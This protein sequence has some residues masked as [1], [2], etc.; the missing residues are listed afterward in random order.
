MK[1]FFLASFIY[2]FLPII[3]L[4][5]NYKI[6]EDLMTDEKEI[7]F[8]ILSEN[9]I[10]NSIGVQ[11]KAILSF[12]C[13]KEPQVIFATRTYNADN[14]ELEIR[15]NK[16]FVYSY[17]WDPASKSIAY[18]HRDPKRF[19]ERTEESDLVTIAWIPYKRR[20]IAAR[21]DLNSQSWK[22]NIQRAKDDGCSLY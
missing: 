16:G 7:S 22:K 10:S 4:A 20:K 21:F 1:K 18:F 19:I 13:K 3:S 2:F 9:T 12:R 17:H 15:W 11:E 5:E 14:I 8:S 6:R